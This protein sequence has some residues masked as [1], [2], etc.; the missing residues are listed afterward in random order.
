MNCISTMP[1]RTAVCG[2]DRSAPPAR[3]PQDI[4]WTVLRHA[5]EPLSIADLVRRSALDPVIATRWLRKWRQAGLLV[6][7]GRQALLKLNGF[8]MRLA[9]PPADLPSKP[10]SQRFQPSSPRQR[11]WTAIRVL[12][13]FELPALMMA[14]EATIKMALNYLG[15]LV[16]AGY[17][18]RIDVRGA[19]HRKYRIVLD[20]GP[21]H[22]SV[23]RVVIEGRPYTRVIDNNNSAQVH[24]ALGPRGRPPGGTRAAAPASASPF[25]DRKD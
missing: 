17:L 5:G 14:A 2:P 18:E 8:A 1:F 16:R 15:D 22:P 12:K 25:F 20:T 24:L 3:A 13:V 23:S 11:I 21:H 7:V 10:L 6:P 4:L 9:E 19:P